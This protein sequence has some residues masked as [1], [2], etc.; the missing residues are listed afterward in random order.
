MHRLFFYAC[1]SLLVLGSSGLA[2]ES[3]IESSGDVDT[4]TAVIDTL[5][6][7]SGL[8]EG[9]MAKINSPVCEADKCYAIEIIFHWDPIGRFVNYDTIPG[10]GL[11]KLD[12]IPFTQADYQKL[13]N[14]LR[15]DKSVLASYQKEQLV[16]DTRISDIDGFTG[17]TIQ[18]IKD[19]VIEGAVYSCYTLWHLAHGPIPHMLQQRTCTL[20]N[21]KLVKK[22]VAMQDQQVNYFLIN[23]FS[24]KDFSDYLPLVL[25]TIAEGTGYFPKNAIEKIPE[26]TLMNDVSQEFF[27]SEFTELNYF[28]QVALLKKIGQHTVNERLLYCFEQSLDARDSYRNELIKEILN[29]NKK[30]MDK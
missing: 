10:Q 19:N 23:N 25:Q 14:I 9:Y 30:S 4:V 18:E 28:T 22:L 6:D 12:H 13:Q 16:K 5:W 2:S 21:E 17:A 27:T 1:I 26:T 3:A 7:Q 24:E 8:L 15:N 11:T 20:F 29:W